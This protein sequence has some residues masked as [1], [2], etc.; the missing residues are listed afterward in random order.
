MDTLL[1]FSVFHRAALLKYPLPKARLLLHLENASQALYKSS[2]EDIQISATA[3]SILLMVSMNSI[4]NMLSPTSALF[5]MKAAREIIDA[6]RLRKRTDDNGA[7]LNFLIGWFIRLECM[8]SSLRT[9]GHRPLILNL[10]D[11]EPGIFADLSNHDNATD[12]YWGTTTRG[13]Y[14]LT[15]VAGLMRAYRKANDGCIEILGKSRSVGRTHLSVEAAELEYQL[16]SLPLCDTFKD[17]CETVPGSWSADDLHLVQ[18]T[19]RYAA[20]IH[21]GRRGPWQELEN[22]ES[23][24]VQRCIDTIIARFKHMISIGGRIKSNPS[25][26]FP[27]ITAGFET[28]NLEYRLFVLEQC[29]VYE[30]YG[31]SHVSVTSDRRYPRSH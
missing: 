27:L 11:E 14:D 16:S 25:M 12:C 5:H 18:R 10:H 20:H 3:V 29:K 2:D 31:L 6:K 9:G 17:G 19:N 7:I 8:Q 24:V 4:F 26:I 23:V 22:S 13:I 21:L 28:H 1:A 30:S 15:R